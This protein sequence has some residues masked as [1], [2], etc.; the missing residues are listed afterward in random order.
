M[1]TSMANAMTAYYAD[2]AGRANALTN[3]PETGNTVINAINSA[4]TT[5][6]TT[7]LDST[8][9]LQTEVIGTANEIVVTNSAGTLTL[10]LPDTIN[11]FVAVN[12]STLTGVIDVPNGGTGI[13]S[14]TEGDILYA[15]T[16]NSLTTLPI[17][18]EN[19]VLYVTSGKPAWGSVPA[20]GAAPYAINPGVISINS[21]PYTLDSSV[22]NSSTVIFLKDTTGT[23]PELLL[24]DGVTPGQLLILMVHETGANPFHIHP[25]I[26]IKLSTNA[27]FDFTDDGD[28][29]T[30][31]W[32]GT[33]WIEISSVKIP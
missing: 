20:A 5:I 16:T 33:D 2:S 13:S 28:N 24:A 27:K 9:L 19:Q 12:A 6:N 15:D 11:A 17:G 21:D 25:A 18:S 22:V 7:A 31:L 29:V 3:S 10:S 4:T 30:L 8:V 14:Y 1:L 26:N 32:C 23:D